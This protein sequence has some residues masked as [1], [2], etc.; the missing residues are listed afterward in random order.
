MKILA[1]DTSNRP[2]SV[3]VMEDDRLLAET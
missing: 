3:A 2:L 1:I